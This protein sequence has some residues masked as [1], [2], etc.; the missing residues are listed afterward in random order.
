MST[1]ANNLFGASSFC[2]FEDPE[3]PGWRCIKEAGWAHHDRMH[4]YAKGIQPGAVPP[5]PASKPPVS[6]PE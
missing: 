6:D 2:G 4:V 5:E 3:R 1:E